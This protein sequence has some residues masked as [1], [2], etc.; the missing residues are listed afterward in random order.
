MSKV[1]NRAVKEKC[2]TMN[3]AWLNGAKTVTFNGITQAEFQA[4]IEDAA[5]VD[6]AIAELEAE[7][8]RKR[9]IRNDKYVA[10]D[11]MRSKVG[12]GVAGD[13]NYGDDSPL[14]GAMGFVR[15][16]ARRYGRKKKL[17]E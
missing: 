10:L 1:D 11:Q 9:E 17:T 16:S 3:D 7:I 5:A 12:M 2:N 14:Y 6:A 8:K 15:K 13:A 4:K